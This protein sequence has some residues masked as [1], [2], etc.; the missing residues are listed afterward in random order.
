MRSRRLSVGAFHLTENNIYCI[1]APAR[2]ST[3]CDGKGVMILNT[4]S[5]ATHGSDAKGQLF[6]GEFPLLYALEGLLVGGYA[7][8]SANTAMLL[9]AM[10][11]GIRGREIADIGCGYGTT[12]YQLARFNPAR[13]LAYDT[14]A[15]M[16]ELADLILRSDDPIEAWLM[17][18]GARVIY[19]ERFA[20]MVTYFE[21]MRRGFRSMRAYAP[22][23][24]LSL[25]VA[26][27][28]SLQGKADIDG[29]AANN[30]IHWPVNK[31]RA[32]HI[33]DGTAVVRVLSKL[34]SLLKMGGVAVLM[35][36]KEFVV[37]DRDPA[38]EEY[39]ESRTIDAHPIYR[40]ANEI[41]NILL[42]R[43][44][45]V[46]RHTPGC[47]R[48]FPITRFGQ[49]ARK[50]GFE[51]VRVVHAEERVLVDPLTWCAVR[52]PIWMG[53]VD[54]PFED[55]LHLTRRVEEMI[56]RA[57]SASDLLEP[58]WQQAFFFVLSKVA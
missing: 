24:R 19:G 23:E 29:V 17:Q 57:G 12:T 41:M 31:L 16:I 26:D 40:Q 2:T 52:M 45:G 47:A 56:K 36:P 13:L 43:E 25:Q 53:G 1:F 10:L 14:S 5:T 49:L 21:L 37:D 58:M 50:S 51:L 46:E 39:L 55:K 33:D 3:G 6:R 11:G 35:E 9:E 8:Q 34:S 42:L 48:L 20:D 32:Q 44:F 54:I 30:V 38:F 28:M 18:H 4:R 15:E 27:I 7:Q 22:L